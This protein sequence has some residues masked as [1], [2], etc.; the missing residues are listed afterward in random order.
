MRNILGEKIERV[1]INNQETIRGMK[2][3]FTSAL[4]DVK[5]VEEDFKSRISLVE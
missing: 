1:I 4:R 5:L 3:D 2:D